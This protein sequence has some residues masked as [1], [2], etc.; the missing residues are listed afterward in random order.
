LLASICFF[1]VEALVTVTESKAG[2]MSSIHFDVFPSRRCLSASPA[3]YASSAW[4]AHPT[5]SFRES[6]VALEYG[7]HAFGALGATLP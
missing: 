1:T 2:K 5:L 4:S 3:P 7:M 6:V